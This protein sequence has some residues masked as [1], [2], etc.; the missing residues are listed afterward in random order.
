MTEHATSSASRPDTYW[1]A[2]NDCIT[3]FITCADPW[4]RQ[5]QLRV[6]LD[7]ERRFNEP[8]ATTLMRIRRT[9]DDE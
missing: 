6:V 4:A 3:D 2:L 5:Q 7:D 9:P 1:Q 8:Y